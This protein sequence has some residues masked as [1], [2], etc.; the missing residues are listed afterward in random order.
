[1]AEALG[2]VSNAH[3]R[4]SPEATSG[5]G[6][7]GASNGSEFQAAGRS[8]I[9]LRR[10]RLVG[11]GTTPRALGG[12]FQPWRR[13]RRR[14]GPRGG[15]IDGGSAAA[16]AAPA[17]GAVGPDQ[18]RPTGQAIGPRRAETCSPAM[19]GRGQ[20]ARCDH[21]GQGCPRRHRSHRRWSGGRRRQDCRPG[22]GHLVNPQRRACAALKRTE[23]GREPQTGERRWHHGQRDRRA[24]AARAGRFR[25]WCGSGPRL[26]FG[27]GLGQAQGGVGGLHGAALALEQPSRPSSVSSRRID[28][29]TAL[30]VICSSRAAQVK[31]RWRAGGLDGAQGGERRSGVR[32]LKADA[33][34]LTRKLILQLIG[35][36]HLRRS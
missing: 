20:A 19:A 7:P 3:D 13:C 24:A 33:L 29:L 1:M 25:G 11:Q 30:W 14:R 12:G 27:V 9:R 31:L 4:V 15:L 17:V 32:S 18:Q 22:L 36:R 26:G 21:L 8:T 23:P 35:L 6:P 16:Q 28:W 10:R 5:H 34:S 2:G